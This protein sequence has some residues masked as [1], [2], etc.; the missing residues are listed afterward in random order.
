MEKIKTS[1][2]LLASP[3][4]GGKSSDDSKSGV[5]LSAEAVFHQEEDGSLVPVEEHQKL[6]A[7]Q[8][9]IPEWHLQAA[10][11]NAEDATFFGK[12]SDDPNDHRTQLT[13][14]EIAKARRICDGCPVWEICLTHAL[15]FPENA[16]VWAGTSATERYKIRLLVQNGN[17]EYD[18]EIDRLRSAR[19]QRRVGIFDRRAK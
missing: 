9:R 13:V 8:K 4:T 10:C 14:T 2:T 3:S 16:G 1:S 11:D 7:W 15:T 5:W 18:Y 6:S 17:T 19:D 12:P